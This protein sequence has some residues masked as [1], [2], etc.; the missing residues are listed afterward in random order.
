MVGSAN[1]IPAC[2]YPL[3]SEYVCLTTHTFRLDFCFVTAC[4]YPP[5]REL[6][7]S[8]LLR[9]PG[10]VLGSSELS[11]GGSGGSPRLANL[12]AALRKVCAHPYLFDGMEDRS[13]DPM[14]EHVISNCAK[15]Q[16]RG[17]R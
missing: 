11:G 15:L 1:D 10:A 12:L 7:K 17:G 4:N 13:L 9:D 14:G 16:V 8:I 5:Q 6:Y 2:R 3:L